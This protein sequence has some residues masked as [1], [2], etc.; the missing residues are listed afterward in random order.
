MLPPE[1]Q[2]QCEYVLS[3]DIRDPGTRQEALRNVQFVCH[4]SAYIPARFDDLQEAA[5]CYQVN[6]EATL[7]LAA[8]ASERGVRRFVQF[9]AGNMYAPSDRPCSESDSLFST[10]CA[11]S[12]FVSKL[13]A[14]IYLT[15]VW[16]HT[17]ME[18]V[19]LRIGTPY[20]PGEP[21]QKVIPTFLRLAAQG[22][23]L[24]MVNGGCAKFNF[25]YAAD[26]ADCAV[27]SLESGLPGVYNVASGEHTSLREM[28]QAVV[29]LFGKPEVPLHIEPAAPGAFLGFPPLAID[30]ARRAWRFEPRSLAAGL[31]EYRDSLAMDGAH[32]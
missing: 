30:K 26:V 1:L 15:H 4:L 18:G 7:E 9:S 11:P 21:S 10:E 27:K 16:K 12:Y 14:E 2:A 31:R 32:P 24:R 25:V 29:E 22:Q 13:A 6:A 8:A 3:G 17:P 23:P 19:I 5:Q 20:G 28:A